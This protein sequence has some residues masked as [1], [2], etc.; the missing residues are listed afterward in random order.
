VARQLIPN[1]TQIPDVI[2]DRW[3]AELSG[4]EFKV[5]L[6]IARRTYGFG[7]DSDRISLSQI[8]DGIVRRDG[9]VLDRGTGISRSS[10]AR[11]LNS[12]EERN[13]V[14]RS[15]NF[16]ESGLEYDESTYRINLDWSPEGEAGSG[17]N[18]SESHGGVVPNSDYPPSSRESR[19]TGVV[20]KSDYVVPNS[21]QVVAKDDRGWSQNRRG[22]V[23]KS[24]PQET[25]QETVQET[26]SKGEREGDSKSLADADA[27]FRNLV[28]ELVAN[29]VGKS[30]AEDLARKDPEGCRR[31]LAYLPYA[32][33]KKSRGAFLVSAI[34]HGYGP[35][36]AYE[37]A[38]RRSKPA[39][40]ARTDPRAIS[41]DRQE[42]LNALN[43]LSEGERQQLEEE[44][45]HEDRPLIAETLERLRRK[46]GK[47]YEEF[48]REI[49]V[50]HL[51]RK[52]ERQGRLDQATLGPERKSPT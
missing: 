15:L 3:M 4:A 32:E 17:G 7:K 9:T 50:E 52:H 11:A 8:A 10:V 27:D 12:L 46:G 28:K 33:I 20:P 5:L 47:V 38:Q 13:I 42:L 48:R 1:S 29:G 37:K 35:P 22:V 23:P 43:S 16:A 39:P 18:E 2:L 24:D 30:V 49:V 44:A 6:Y 14:I 40:S 25:D 21:D 36:A 31:S 19:K 41:D 34:R 45:F 26:A 51:R